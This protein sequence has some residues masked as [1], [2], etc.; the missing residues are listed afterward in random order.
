MITIAPNTPAQPACPA[1][2]PSPI[3]KAEVESVAPIESV[4][5]STATGS[6]PRLDLEVNARNRG[7]IDFFK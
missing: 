5:D 2:E 7:A 6:V 3:T 4:K 1:V